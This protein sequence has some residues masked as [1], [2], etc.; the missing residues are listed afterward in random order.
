MP[1][2]QHHLLAL[3]DFP[4]RGIGLISRPGTS[5]GGESDM[6]VAGQKPGPGKKILLVRVDFIAGGA[7]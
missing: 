2:T 7:E 1:D 3:V 4:L 6:P 5:V